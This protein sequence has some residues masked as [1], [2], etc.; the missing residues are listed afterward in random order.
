MRVAGGLVA[1]A[2]LVLLVSGCS[3]DLPWSSAPA[4][5]TSPCPQEVLGAAEG[6]ASVRVGFDDTA[7]PFGEST[8]VR[9]CAYGFTHLSM[10]VSVPPGVT[11][12]PREAEVL[13]DGEPVTFEV[14]AS[15]GA[16]GQITWRVGSK[17]EGLEATGKG[18][19]VVTTDNDWHLRLPGY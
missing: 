8:P 18:P 6:M 10:V 5:S 16:S 2:G 11:V 15:P 3:V 19:A 9:W 7:R 17:A 12:V 1:G 4:T 14:T 13:A